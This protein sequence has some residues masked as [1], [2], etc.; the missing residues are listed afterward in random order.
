[1]FDMSFTGWFEGN[2]SRFGSPALPSALVQPP[3]T[4]GVGWGGC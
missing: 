3:C 1:M 2:L 4:W